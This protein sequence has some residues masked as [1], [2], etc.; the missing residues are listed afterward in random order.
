M[1]NAQEILKELQMLSPLLAGI[2]KTNVFQVPAGYFDGFP[3]EMLTRVSGENIL[4]PQAK[5]NIVPMSVP[6]GYFDSLSQN[7]L[8]KIR[9]LYPESAH[10]ELKR[11]APALASLQQINVYDVPFGYFE[12]VAGSV[13]NQMRPAAKV[14]SLKPRRTWFQVAAAA[15]VAGAIAVSSLQIFKTNATSELA[16]TGSEVNIEQY[17]SLT[18][19]EI[20]REIASLSD[21]AIASYLEKN[22]NVMDNELLITN[23]DNSELPDEI[24]YLT[25]DNTLNLYLDKINTSQVNSN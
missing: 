14:I 17:A 10:D 2:P 25:N 16:T 21:E 15:V 11:V 6:E 9:E 18:P 22:G 7:I 1:N 19:Q 12:N 4:L 20:N 23:T 24:D 5:S 8:M 13:I 3:E